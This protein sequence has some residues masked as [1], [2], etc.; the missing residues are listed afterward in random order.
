MWWYAADV[1]G[2]GVRN[3]YGTSAPFC[4]QVA[5][6]ALWLLSSS[7]WLGVLLKETNVLVYVALRHCAYRLCTSSWVSMAA[8]LPD[9]QSTALP[10]RSEWMVVERGRQDQ[11]CA[12]ASARVRARQRF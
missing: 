2:E 6:G 7:H 3:R 1:R 4:F 9:S 10:G 11:S 5:A 8:A 12:A